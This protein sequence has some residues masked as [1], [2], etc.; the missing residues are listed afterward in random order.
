MPIKS[1]LS[2][3]EYASLL[4]VSTGFFHGAIPADDAAQLFG[5]GLVYNL[6]GNTRLTTAGRAR[7]KQGI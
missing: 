5:L 2:Q 4:E 1:V 6:M 7:L 3:R